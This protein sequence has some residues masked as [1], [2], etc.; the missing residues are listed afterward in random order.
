MVITKDPYQPGADGIV[1][2]TRDQVDDLVKKGWKEG[3]MDF[4]TDVTPFTKKQ[5]RKV[6]EMKVKITFGSSP[7]KTQPQNKEARYSDISEIGK[8]QLNTFENTPMVPKV[9]HG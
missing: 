1:H 7:Q 3:E 6:T 8:S 2:L 4:V 5:G 9:G